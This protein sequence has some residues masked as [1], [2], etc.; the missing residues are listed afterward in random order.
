MK[1]I[2]FLALLGFFLI[3]LTGCGGGNSTPSTQILP[4]QKGYVLDSPISGLDFEC[5]DIIGVTND[6]GMF[7][8]RK[9]PVT[10]KIGNLTIGTISKIPADK[11][12]YPQDILGKKRTN[13]TDAKVIE[14]TRFLQSLDDDGNIDKIIKITPNIKN[15]FTTKQTLST[16][17]EDSQK[18]LIEEAGKTYVTTQ[19][20]MT[21]L[22]DNIEKLTSIVVIP[23]TMTV[24]LGKSATLKAQGSYSNDVKRDITTEVTWSSSKPTVATINGTKAEAKNI[25]TT[26]I[27]A[28]LKGI[29][30][31]A[32]L[33]VTA[34][35]N[36]R[37]KVI[38]QNITLNEDNNITIALTGS[39]KD[40]DNLT[41]KIVTPPTHGTM[42]DDVYTP[43]LNYNGKDSFTFVANDGKIDSEIATI[44]ITVTS[45]N[46]LPTIDAGA[47]QNIKFGSNVTFTSTASDIDG[48]LKD[49]TWKEGTKILASSQSF[50]K[51]DFSIGTHILTA[52]VSDNL[53][54]IATDTVTVTVT[55]QGKPLPKTG[56]LISYHNNDD[57]DLQ[58]GAV[59]SYTRGGATDIVTD[60]VTGLMWQDSLEAKTVT[61]YWEE[62]INYCNNLNLGNYTDWR[63]PTTKE[64][65]Y[66]IDKGVGERLLNGVGVQAID[67]TFNS[68]FQFSQYFK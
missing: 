37:P 51:S 17:S 8:C 54:A 59:R 44:N 2:V 38:D 67:S 53:G 12:V 18:A 21:H 25:G 13:F 16:L 39:D 56:Q 28:T 1:D 33:I 40:S 65:T 4:L 24:E 14:L 31:I 60:N 46:D 10:F 49:Y 66:L 55:C 42:K 30:K 52:S 20:A 34:I 64:L 48:T 5:G 19:A 43:A 11:K 3:V 29:S 61:S 68:P 36:K 50:N 41:F 6:E 47:D 32:T 26:T 9:F 62:A 57:G 45:I 35:P 7:E 22:K 27:K 58:K 23:S 15:S 63:L